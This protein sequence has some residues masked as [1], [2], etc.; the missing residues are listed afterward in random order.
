MS[1]SGNSRRGNE[2]WG[3]AGNGEWGMRVF[4]RITSTHK[5]RNRGGG[6]GGT[7]T[8]QILKQIRVECPFEAYS[9]AL[10]CQP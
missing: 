1:R 2:E 4:S 6:T 10:F 9:V 3:M 5:R 7:C 8:P